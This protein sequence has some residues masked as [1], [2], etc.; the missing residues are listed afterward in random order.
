MVS[1]WALAAKFKN[2]LPISLLLHPDEIFSTWTKV[3]VATFGEDSVIGELI[4]R[5]NVLVQYASA[6]SSLY[7]LVQLFLLQ[8]LSSFFDRGQSWSPSSLELRVIQPLAYTAPG[9]S[10]SVNM[11]CSATFSCSTYVWHVKDPWQVVCTPFP[12]LFF[13]IFECLELCGL[14]RKKQLHG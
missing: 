11:N 9:I 12:S 5:R 8:L 2:L 7:V 13:F 4:F 10:E 14:P 6:H 1:I 3:H